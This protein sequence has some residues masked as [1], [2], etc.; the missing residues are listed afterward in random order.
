MIDAGFSDHL[1]I[2]FE[3]VCDSPAP[4]CSQSVSYSRFI[5]PSTTSL[6]SEH[7]QANFVDAATDLLT[8]FHPISSVQ[9]A[10]IVFK[11]KSS[12]CESD[13]I[14]A[15]LFKEVFATLSPAVTAIIN[16]SLA[17]GVVPASFKHAV[18]HPLLKKPHLDPSILSNFRPISKLP[19]SQNY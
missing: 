18:V 1:P 11:V 7:Y 14:Q 9:L 15:G 4:T 13:V 3:F 16:N 5:Q 12:S 17:N 19:L 8:C 10:D 6:F 2:V